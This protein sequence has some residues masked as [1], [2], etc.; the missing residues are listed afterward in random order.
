MVHDGSWSK[1]KRAYWDT[2]VNEAHARQMATM[3]FPT[4]LSVMNDGFS[5]HWQSHSGALTL[6]ASCSSSAKHVLVLMYQ[7][8]CEVPDS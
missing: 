4:P 6:A 3:E 7:H 5:R 2:R 8:R 1:S